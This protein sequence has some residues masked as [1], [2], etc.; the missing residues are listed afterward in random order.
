MS[1]NYYNFNSVK[2]QVIQAKLSGLC[3][4]SFY[5]LFESQMTKINEDTWVPIC[6]ERLCTKGWCIIILDI[7]ISN[8]RTRSISIYY[9][10]EDGG[11]HSACV[12]LYGTILRELIKNNIIDPSRLRKVN[13]VDERFME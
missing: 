12:R 3:T 11:K 1:D 2:E 13:N 9:R 4:F 6:R 8:H 7:S 10:L 5:P